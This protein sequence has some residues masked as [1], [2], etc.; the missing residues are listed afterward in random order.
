MPRLQLLRREEGAVLR[1]RNDWYLPSAF[2]SST[3]LGLE[4]MVR[5]AGKVGGWND[6]SGWLR[7]LHSLCVSWTCSPLRSLT[8]LRNCRPWSLCHPHPR[9]DLVRR[10]CPLA[11]R[12]RDDLLSS[13][14]VP[15]W[16]WQEG[17]DLR[18][19]RTRAPGIDVGQRHGYVDSS[20]FRSS[21]RADGVV[22]VPRP[23]LFLT[24]TRSSR[25][26]VSCAIPQPFRQLTTCL[27][28]Q[29]SSASSLRTSSSP[30]TSRRPPQSGAARSISSSAPR[31]RV[32]SPSSRSSSSSSAPRELLCFVDF[33]RRS[34][35]PCSA[36][37]WSA[38]V[39]RLQAVSSEERTRSSSFPLPFLVR[40]LLTDP[41]LF[42]REM[43]ALAAAKNIRPWIEVRPMSDASQAV[44]DM[45]AGKAHFRYVLE[46]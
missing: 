25:M 32:T 21:F 20:R 26:R 1:P 36:R 14:A 31:S 27:C 33:P 12:R 2:T 15:R 34:S 44:K 3:P 17:G 38:S 18:C 5:R 24:P 42:R 41:L 39:S 45:D 22:Q 16:A 28:S 29:R 46:N 40:T 6:R 4:L 43:L 37:R 11:L 9:R 35:L 19:W 7:R 23:L 10:G 13:Q 8:L 30:R